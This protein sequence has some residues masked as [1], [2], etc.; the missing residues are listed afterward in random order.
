M[1]YKNWE[2]DL[3]KFELVP[4]VKQNK[5]ENQEYLNTIKKDLFSNMPFYEG[6]LFNK[7]GSIRSA[8]YLNKGIVNTPKRK[9]YI[10]MI[11]FQ[12]RSF[13]KETGIDLKVSWMPYIRTH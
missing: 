12:N 8:I 5:T 7:K 9:D 13:W 10:L 6:L 2:N 4:F 3:P 1:T 11:L